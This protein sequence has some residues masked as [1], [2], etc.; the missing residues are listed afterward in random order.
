[1]YKY[2]ICC[3]GEKG[4]AASNYS[5]WLSFS[6]DPANVAEE[7]DLSLLLLAVTEKFPIYSINGTG[8][9]GMLCIYGIM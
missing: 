5:L 9:L 1:M 4:D 3:K 8:K 2:V 7:N 6:K